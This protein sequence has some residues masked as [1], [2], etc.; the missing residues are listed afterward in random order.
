MK[1]ALESFCII[2]VV[3][4]A[5]DCSFPSVTEAAGSAERVPCSARC[6]LWPASTRFGSVWSFVLLDDV[7][8]YGHAGAATCGEFLGT[9]IFHMFDCLGTLYHNV[10][11]LDNDNITA[12]VLQCSIAQWDS[13]VQISGLSRSHVILHKLDTAFSLYCGR[14]WIHQKMFFDCGF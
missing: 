9:H 14:S 13:S 7:S 10:R 6:S 11:R 1:S 12:T 2:M 5:C 4:C 3:C 8:T